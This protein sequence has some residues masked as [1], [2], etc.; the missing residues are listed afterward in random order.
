MIVVMAIAWVVQRQRQNGS[1]TDPFWLYGMGITGVFV[2][3]LPVSGA[4]GVTPRQALVAL[5]IG[6]W[7]LRLGTYVTTRVLRSPEDG[8]YTQLRRVSSGA[9]QGIMFLF[10]QVQAW[11]AALFAL[12]IYV[13][14]HHPATG[15]RVADGLGVLLMA[16]GLIGE[17]VADE[18]LRRFK[19]DP[20]AV[21]K[22]C[23]RGL[24]AWTRHP[25]YLFECLFWLGLPIIGI[26]LT[27]AYPA[28]WLS[29]PGATFMFLVLTR[30][31]GIPP[32]EESLI[33][34]KGDAYRAYQA[35]VS[36][37]FPRPPRA[38]EARA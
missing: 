22:V 31:T 14:A 34:S 27:G 16:T 29:L 10:L 17:A 9:F 24:W 6:L 15:L 30:V 18:Q 28:G 8:R 20:G 32:L 37:F 3:L 4:S 19:A 13:A 26:D 5:M 33:A 12:S 35:R 7:S 11:A 21:G 2:A 1:W 25:N 38:R 36:A 23:D